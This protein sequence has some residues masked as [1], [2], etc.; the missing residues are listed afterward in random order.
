M[1][2]QNKITKAARGQSCQVRVPG[3]P[4]NTETVVLAH[5]RMSGTSG[6]GMKPNDLQG[7]WCCDWCHSQVDGRTKSEFTHEELRHW[8]A[9]GVFRT[10]QRLID[11][12]I[13]KV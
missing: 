7:A 5:Y 12:G 4:D 6:M 8:H 2:K 1:S 9:E 3:C 13:L 10:I 11:T